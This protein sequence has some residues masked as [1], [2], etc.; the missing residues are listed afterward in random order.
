MTT[1]L[2]V[3]DSPVVR[4]GLRMILEAEADLDVVAEASSGADALE[5]AGR[6]NPDVVLMDV[7]ISG[8]DGL[9]T[10]GHLLARWPDV[11]VL[12]LTTDDTEDNVYEALRAGA[13]GFVIKDSPSEQVVQAVRTVAA[14]NAHFS[15]TVARKLLD[16]VS[17][18]LPRPEDSSRIRGL[19]ERDTRLLRLIAR[20]YRNAEIATELNLTASTVKTYVSRLLSAIGARDRVHAVLIAHRAGLAGL[21]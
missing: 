5:E 6:H 7:R 3:D 12:V 2:V 15:P 9:T 21:R 10:M 17:A 8:M 16:H 4:M 14:G 19:A 18:T 11:R 13:R 20:G 1:V